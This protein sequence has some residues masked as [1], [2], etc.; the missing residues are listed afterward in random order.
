MSW[1]KVDDRWHSHPKTQ[2]L[3]LAA[4]GLWAKA[5]SWCMD[6]LTDGRVPT[7]SVVALGGSA[8]LGAEL[9]SSG[10]WE[11]VDGGYQFHDWAVMQPASGEIRAK[12]ETD[13]LRKESGRKSQAVQRLSARNP[14]GLRAAS[15]RNPVVPDPDPDQIS[16]E[17]SSNLSAAEASSVS[18]A[19]DF[20]PARAEASRGRS[21]LRSAG[22]ELELD[23]D[24]GG[25]WARPLAQIARYPDAEWAIAATTIAQAV[26]TERGRRFV[27]PQHIVDY[28]QAY[29]SGTQPG[30]RVDFKADDAAVKQIADEV[31]RQAVRDEFRPKLAKCDNDW[32]R[33]MLCQKRDEALRRLERQL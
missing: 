17:N 33:E 10:L 6:Y 14:S 4:A 27:T 8:E 11:A 24:H 23:F 16:S 3:S 13:R 20:D 30:K 28:W 18:A 1:F 19:A 5:G 7:A 29:S 21:R 15:D 12:R 32:D 2:G 25:K 22:S 26:S 9:T 31:R